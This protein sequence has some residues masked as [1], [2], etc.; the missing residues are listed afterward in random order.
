MKDVPF[1]LALNN[2]N[3]FLCGQVIAAKG[4]SPRLLLLHPPE[5]CRFGEE[6]RELFPQALVR[7]WNPGETEL[8]LGEF[9]T[10]EIGLLLSVNFGYLF[11]E[12]VLARLPRAL[13][14]HTGYLPW[15]R[16]SN[17]NVWSLVEGTPAGV[18]LHH[19]TSVLD[20]GDIVAQA[21]VPVEPHDTG[22][23]LYAKLQQASVLL[24]EEH[25][26]SLLG[27]T[28]PSC[29]AE[30]VG[31]CHR[32]RD[33]KELCRLDLEEEMPVGQLLDRLRALSF[34][35]YRNAYFV[36]DGKRVYVDISLHP[37]EEE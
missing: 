7:E 22:K 16:G 19:M 28:L 24:L 6:I 1:A 32:V 14:L 34:P 21:E 30:G 8:L 4:F 5:T 23:S 33:M 18:T 37:G 17:P 31:S 10:L 12:K 2:E 11:P 3:G 20:G 13:N 26:D 15:N 27:E 36:K 25:F 35:P 9:Q 29:R